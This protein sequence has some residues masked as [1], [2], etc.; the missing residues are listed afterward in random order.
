MGLIRVTRIE[1]SSYQDVINTNGFLG[2][3]NSIY[4][5]GFDVLRTNGQVFYFGS[6]DVLPAPFAILVDREASKWMQEVSLKKNDHFFRT[7]N[8]LIRGP[9]DNCPVILDPS[10]VIDLK[11]NPIVPFPPI[12]V[13]RHW[14]HF[15]VKAI[16]HWGSFTGIAGTLHL[17]KS[18]LPR[19]FSL[20]PEG[21]S[22]WSKYA[23]P[24]VNRLMKGASEGDV[25]E[26]GNGW[27][28]LVGLGPGLTPAG[29]D[30]L[31]GFLA[32]HWFIST[33]FHEMLLNCEVSSRLKWA[34]RKTVRQAN[35]FLCSAL[36]GLFSETLQCAINCVIEKEGL[37]VK[38]ICFSAKRNNQASIRDFLEW[39]QSSGS[40]TL[41]GVVFGLRSMT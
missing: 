4:S 21:M 22:F 37:G 2:K 30:F 7:G 13:L 28:S 39:G 1:W 20:A 27:E 3:V 31:V 34:C 33:A 40:D 17:L 36:D 26:F 19:D 38:S 24:H 5:N 18:E 10:S 25:E 23:M 9:K 11:V 29:D 32:A 41:T 6:G 14:I 15:L 12:D 16:V 35:Q 8:L